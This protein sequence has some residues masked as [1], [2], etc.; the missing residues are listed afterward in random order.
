MLTLVQSRNGKDSDVNVQQFPDLLVRLTHSKYPQG[1]E[2]ALDERIRTMLPKMPPREGQLGFLYLPP[3]R[4]QGIS[5]AG[6]QTTIQIPELDVVFDMGYCTRS[7]LSSGTLALTHAHMDHVGA[8]PYWLS[9]RHFQKLGVGRIVCHPKIAGPLERMM[10]TWVDLEQQATPYEIIPLSPGEDFPLKGNLVLRAFA[11]D[12]TSPSLAFAVVEKRSKLKPEYADCPQ[13]RIR[14]LKK[15][16]VDITSIIEIPVIAIT[17]DT[18][19]CPTLECD[20]FVNAQTLLT[21]CTFFA[22]EHYDRARMGRHLHFSDLK[23]LLE[24]W[25][26]KHVVV[27]HIS[28]RTSLAFARQEIDSLENGRYKDRVHLLMDYRNNRR[29]YEKQLEAAESKAQETAEANS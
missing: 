7:S 21:E 5:V 24:V 20:E 13:E 17:G 29:R 1:R 16:G 2:S 25:K 14:E 18:S 6:E 19:Y 9:Q 22:P 10:K 12:H 26:A 15:D 3:Y 8:V 4:I 23:K 11:T 28:R 27:T